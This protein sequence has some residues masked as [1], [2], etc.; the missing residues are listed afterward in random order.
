M[1]DLER[2]IAE[3]AEADRRAAERPDMDGNAVMEYLGIEPGPAVGQAVKM[4][5][6]AKRNEGEL[7]RGE[8]ER[9][10]D[11]WWGEQNKS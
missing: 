3:L 1:D 5:L 10:L 2:R 4:L 11:E 8:L 7:D 6:E 9:R